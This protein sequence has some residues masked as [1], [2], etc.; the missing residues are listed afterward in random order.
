MVGQVDNQ[1]SSWLVAQCPYQFWATRDNFARETSSQQYRDDL[2]EARLSLEC[3][4][5]Q[6]WLLCVLAFRYY[7]ELSVRPS[8][9]KTVK[10]LHLHLEPSIHNLVMDLHQ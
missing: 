8:A 3:V 1:G 6:G 5:W 9:G 2:R 10:S 4:T 7:N